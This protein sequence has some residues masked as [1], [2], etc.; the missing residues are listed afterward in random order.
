MHTAITLPEG[1]N[2]MK[3]LVVYFS[4]FGNTQR[5]AEAIAETL[6]L[7]MAVDCLPLDRLA[8]AVL[9]GVDL[10]I[11]GSPTHKMNLPEAVRPVF[12]KLPKK[13]LKEVSVATFDTSYQM[14][15]LLKRFTAGK[16]LDQKLRKL[17]G[18]RVVPPE[19]FVVTAREGP[20]FDGELERAGDWAQVLLAQ[21]ARR[22]P[23]VNHDGLIA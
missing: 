1:M 4:K 3:A 17:G 10:V 20:L 14:S 6:E 19:I 18:R 22:K 9:A 23:A 15:W 5:V 13:V 21:H 12:D 2:K 7:E 8:G 16:R 11:M